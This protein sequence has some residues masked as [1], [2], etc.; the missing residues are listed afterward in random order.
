MLTGQAAGALAA[1]CVLQKK[2]PREINVREVQN[3]LLNAGAY[4]M[5]YID[6]PPTHPYF[7]VIQ[8]IG[9]T[10]ILKGTGIPFKWAN[11]TWFYPDS[12]IMLG[13]FYEGFGEYLDQAFKTLD[14]ILTVNHCMYE[15]VSFSS[16][17]ITKKNIIDNWGKLGLKNY[18]ADRPIK[19]FEIA[20]LI[21]YYLKPFETKQINHQGS[22]M[23]TKTK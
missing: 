9:A 12:T 10:G 15:V 1:L 8:K 17:K 18:D 21:D 13:E 2:Q 22:F 6:V 16:K 5:P 23:N 7:K 19:R 3:K 14:D 20:V 11:Q 4:I